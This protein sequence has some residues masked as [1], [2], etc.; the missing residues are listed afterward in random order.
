MIN[1]NYSYRKN[2]PN[3]KNRYGAQHKQKNQRILSLVDQL[4][5]PDTFV[6]ISSAR[7]HSVERNKNIQ[8][9]Q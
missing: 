2:Q 6:P 4:Q 9:V 7:N 3:K 5:P 1:I 8:R